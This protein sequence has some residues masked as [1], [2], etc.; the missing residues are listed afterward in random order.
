MEDARNDL[1]LVHVLRHSFRPSQPL[2]EA[3]ESFVKPGLKLPEEPLL[4]GSKEVAVDLVKYNDFKY[5]KR[6]D[7][8][9]KEF[10]ERNRPIYIDPI[11]HFRQIGLKAV[12]MAFIPTAESVPAFNDAINTLDSVP[13]ILPPYKKI[14]RYF[15][16][17][18]IPNTHIVQGE[19][20]NTRYHALRKALASTIH[21][22]Y[23]V[24][25]LDVIGHDGKRHVIPIE[26][27]PVEKNPFDID[28]S[29]LS[30]PL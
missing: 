1:E 17:V 13:T 14:P 5:K 15:L 21:S 25:P 16:Y 11:M 30:L 9:R 24:R 28:D 23:L 19:E 10:K 4:Y 27:R 18:D 22:M 26:E 7:A 2:S 6:E 3:I 29:P 8:A 12:R 20:W